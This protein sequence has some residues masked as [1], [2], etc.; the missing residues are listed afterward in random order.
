MPK[1]RTASISKF[2][3]A[4][5]C[6]G[7]LCG[8][9][10]L[11]QDILPDSN[12]E[13]KDF[14]LD[15]PQAKEKPPEPAPK[16]ETPAAQ[17]VIAPTTPAT[18]PAQ[19]PITKKP[20]VSAPKPVTPAVDADGA[21]PEVAPTDAA[22]GAETTS[23]IPPQAHAAESA[24]VQ[25]TSS[26]EVP[27]TPGYAQYWLWAVAVLAALLSIALFWIWKSRRA[28]V[29]ANEPIVTKPRAPVA[30][31]PMPAAKPVLA[32]SSLNVRFDPA[33]ARLSVANLTVKGRLH[34]RYE[35]DAPLETLKLRTRVMS[36]CD[37][38]KALIDAFHSDQAA[39]EIE[40][41]GPVVPGEEIDLTLEMRVPRDAL[42]A[43][44]WRERRFIAPIVLINIAS[45]DGT[46]TPC[47]VSCVVGQDGGPG[48]ARL[49]PIP[50]DRGPKLFDALQFRPIA[51]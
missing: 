14:R 2:I 16:V 11:A 50:I 18:Q 37:G 46:V 7:L 3:Y 8:T 48:S 22:V 15:K 39:G 27:D 36:A 49:Q 9:P 21:V 6:A 13:L 23:D 20:P 35:G 5:A 29:F 45:E 17:P 28:P 19:R 44:D 4:L 38:Q 33:D 47:R 43:F 41:L 10:S 12:G 24:A 32:A 30:P 40:S 1:L 26:T 31:R 25:E 51:A 34:L 42:Q